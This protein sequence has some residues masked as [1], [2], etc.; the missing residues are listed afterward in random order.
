MV[1]T[2]HAYKAPS[3]GFSHLGNAKI[4]S[5]VGVLSDEIFTHWPLPTDLYTR[6]L[7]CLHILQRSQD[8]SWVS[9]LYK[10]FFR[11]CTYFQTLHIFRLYVFSFVELRRW[12]C[13][14][15]RL[16]W[17]S[18]HD[19]AVLPQLNERHALNLVVQH[20]NPWGGNRRFLLDSHVIQNL[21]ILQPLH[22]Q[23]NHS[24]IKLFVKYDTKFIF[25]KYQ[26]FNTWICNKEK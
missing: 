21:F 3:W 8:G 4:Q 2:L 12:N 10:F 11:P 24:I 9:L 1:V 6:S 20:S 23:K 25:F 26:N 16:T 22:F 19:Y 5:A 14:T 17:H 18:L 15:V 13:L 7:H